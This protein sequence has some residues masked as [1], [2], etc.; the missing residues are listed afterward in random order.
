MKHP[1]T[2]EQLKKIL[3]NYPNLD[4][5]KIQ[6]IKERV[7]A[8]RIKPAPPGQTW[9]NGPVREKISSKTYNLGSPFEWKY[10]NY[11]NYPR[12][13]ERYIL[14]LEA[15]YDEE[16]SNPMIL[17]FGKYQGQHISAIPEDYLQWSIKSSKD[18]I[19]LF[20]AELERREAVK[21]AS[22]GIVGQIIR[23]GFKALAAKVHPDQGGSDA[24]FIAL[25]ASYEQ[26]LEISKEVADAQRSDQT[27]EAST[28][29][30]DPFASPQTR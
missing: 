10:D 5:A 29:G 23:A 28:G 20:E 8:S 12:D 3:G 21:L 25:K 27:T 24:Q 15:P 6:E 4:P 26:L 18:T 19:S 13:P 22:E 14:K 11:P 30:G 1:L 9:W 7:E 17:K 16:I 2:E